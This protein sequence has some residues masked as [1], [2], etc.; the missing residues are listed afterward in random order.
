[1]EDITL[2]RLKQTILAG[3]TQG[4]EAVTILLR[5]LPLHHPVPSLDMN[6]KRATCAA[7]KYRVSEGTTCGNNL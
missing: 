4:F 2:E 7:G 6:T 5:V 3:N 1:M